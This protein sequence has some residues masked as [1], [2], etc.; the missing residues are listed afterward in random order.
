MPWKADGAKVSFS[1]LLLSL[2]LSCAGTRA[3]PCE[4]DV[5]RYTSCCDEVR[6]MYDIRA[7][8]MKL[9]G[10]MAVSSWATCADEDRDSVLE[11]VR[12]SAAARTDEAREYTSCVDEHARAR[13]A[14]M[15]GAHSMSICPV[16]ALLDL[17]RL[18]DATASDP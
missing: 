12:L 15:V 7:L 2:A 9:L 8:G 10:S 17:D 1:I 6:A 14:G 13:S 11:Y 5:R 18:D 4:E 16:N 3:A